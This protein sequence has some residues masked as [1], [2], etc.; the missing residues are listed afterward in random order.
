M[1]ARH[2]E[3]T[4]A[5][6]AQPESKF[7]YFVI[8]VKGVIGED[9][10]AAHMTLY[11]AKA[12]NLSPSVV[13][14][15]ID[16]P[17]GLV[18]DAE[19]MVSALLKAKGLRVVALVR[20]ALSAGVPVALC[21]REIYVTA[22]T[23]IG[24]G[25]SYI[26]DDS[27]VPVHLPKDVAE[28]WQSIWRATCRVAAEHG[29]HST[30]I[31]EAMIDL[32]FALTMRKEK[33]RI[34]LERDGK[35]EVLKARG[36]ILTL[37][38]REAVACGLAKDISEDYAALGK[39]MG[40][41]GWRLAE[42]RVA[43]R[44]VKSKGFDSPVELEALMVAKIRSLGLD[45]DSVTDLQLPSLLE[46][47]QAWYKQQ[48]FVG[49]KVRWAVVMDGASEVDISALRRSLAAKRKTEKKMDNFAWGLGKLHAKMTALETEI[50]NRE[51]YP[52]T[53]KGWSAGPR[54]LPIIAWVSKSAKN[55]L[56]KLPSKSELL[57]KG[58]I[59]DVSYRTR[60]QHGKSV[61]DPQNGLLLLHVSL[62]RC[63]LVEGE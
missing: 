54:Q 8:P 24:G 53:V 23:T 36:K 32:D 10:K 11:L 17:G 51:H 26:P 39:Q 27:G 48:R 56:L 1:R 42:R 58:R 25:V 46:K 3:K 62:E 4:A 59:R 43:G 12:A 2:A 60:K 45:D 47:W 35:G 30:L 49:R 38:G 16:T 9:F 34:V 55:K 44:A 41:A 18:T 28:K 21:C 20:R 50:R 31:P 14:L 29:G 19:Q 6:P 15:D 7:S 22:G 5:K 40:M 33:E 37:T 52:I 13:I 57:L 63:V 61:P